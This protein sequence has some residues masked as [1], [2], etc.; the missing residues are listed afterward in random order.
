MLKGK[1]SVLIIED[2]KSIRLLLSA[3]LKRNFEVYSLSDGLAGM[4]WLNEGNVPDL[5]VLDMQMP[6]VDGFQFLKILKK[7]GIL[8]TIPVVVVSGN[9]SELDKQSCMALGAEFYF[10][11]PFDP[12][13]LLNKISGI[14]RPVAA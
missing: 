13:E 10:Q 5:I 8:K 1:K 2:Q 11:K 14:L 3:I 9:D 4:A 6:R 12:K 7:S